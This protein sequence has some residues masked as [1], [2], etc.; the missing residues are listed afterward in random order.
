LPLDPSELQRFIKSRGGQATDSLKTSW[1]TVR[2]FYRW[3]VKQE[4]LDPVRNPFLCMESPKGKTPVPRILSLQQ[5]RRL[6]DVSSLSFNRALILML[7]RNGKFVPYSL[8]NDQ[9]C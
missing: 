6:V 4:L 7:P 9:Y 1:R 3:L 8:D 2:T 5:M